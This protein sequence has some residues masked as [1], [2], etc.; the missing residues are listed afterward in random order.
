M[1]N[2]FACRRKGHCTEI[3]Y[4]VKLKMNDTIYKLNARFL[5]KDY[6]Q[7]I[8]IDYFGNFS[9]FAKLV[10]IRLSLALALGKLWPIYQLDLNNPF[11]HGH[12]NEEVYILHSDG[13]FKTKHAEVYKFK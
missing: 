1:T 10:E 4:K 8:G 11:L 7:V 13:Y 3:I 6:H 2:H 12:L 9:L 5:A